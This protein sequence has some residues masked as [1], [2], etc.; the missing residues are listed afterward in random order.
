MQESLDNLMELLVTVEISGVDLSEPWIV[1]AKKFEELG[2]S[3][4]TEAEEYIFEVEDSELDNANERIIEVR[5]QDLNS[6]LNSFKDSLKTPA[7]KIIQ[8]VVETKQSKAI[9]EIITQKR[10]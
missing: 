4:L 3:S 1:E 8:D 9:H 7:S 2:Q 6:S 5:I 10:N